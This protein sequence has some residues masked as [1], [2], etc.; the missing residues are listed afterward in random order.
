[1]LHSIFYF[2][3]FKLNRL[4]P[5]TAHPATPVRKYVLCKKK[6]KKIAAFFFFFFNRAANLFDFHLNRALLGMTERAIYSSDHAYRC[7]YSQYRAYRSITV[8]RNYSENRATVAQLVL[9]GAC[10]AVALG[11]Y[12]PAAVAG[13]LSGATAGG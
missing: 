9:T 3:F 7:S 5:I 2:F 11:R 10:L 8:R 4:L 12:C 13:A 6:K 1:M